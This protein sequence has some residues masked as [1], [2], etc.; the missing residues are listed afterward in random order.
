MCEMHCVLYV[1]LCRCELALEYEAPQLRVYVRPCVCA[2]AMRMCVYKCMCF[3]ELCGGGEVTVGLEWTMCVSA[4]QVC[5]T[6]AYAV[7]QRAC[8]TECSDQ[9]VTRFQPGSDEGVTGQRA[10]AGSVHSVRCE[11]PRTVRCFCVWARARARLV[12]CVVRVC[13]PSLALQRIA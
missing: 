11:C 12:L 3:C 8:H 10:S 7:R 6:R 2:A 4:K 9:G 13:A 1:C 5:L